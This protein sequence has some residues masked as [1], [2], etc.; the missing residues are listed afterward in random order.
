MGWDHDDYWEIARYPFN[1]GD[2]LFL[3]TDG[4][5]EAKNNHG[6]EFGENRLQGLFNEITRSDKL[7]EKV[8]Q[9]VSDFCLGNFYDDLTMFMI[10]RDKD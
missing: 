2:S 1:P 3:Y 4:L 10:R 5:T 8:F 7:V 6:E 9:Q